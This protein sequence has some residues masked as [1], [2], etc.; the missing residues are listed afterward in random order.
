MRFVTTGIKH[1]PLSSCCKHYH[2]AVQMISWIFCYI[3]GRWSR[4]A[5]STATDDPL[6]VTE[7]DL[8][9]LEEAK[10]RW[11][12]LISP[13]VHAHLFIGINLSSRPQ[14]LF[15]PISTDV[16]HLLDETFGWEQWKT[17]SWVIFLSLNSLWTMCLV[18]MISWMCS[19]L[20][21]NK[22]LEERLGF[23]GTCSTLWSIAHRDFFCLHS[24]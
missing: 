13:H 10:E 17:L 24:F 20:Y 4:P 12:L 7:T 19:F 2:W 16:L 23:L 11:Q 5:L 6:D 22:E 1:R 3:P 14:P 8:T 21:Q 18:K 9:A 15:Q